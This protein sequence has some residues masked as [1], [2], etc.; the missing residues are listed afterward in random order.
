LID[1]SFLLLEKNKLLKG[2]Q[3][4][5]LGKLAVKLS[6]AGSPSLALFLLLSIG[7]GCQFEAT[8]IVCMMSA[9][10]FEL[11]NLFLDIPRERQHEEK[12][13]R[14]FRN[15]ICRVSDTSDHLNLLQTYMYFIK[16]IPNDFRLQQEKAKRGMI[17]LNVVKNAQKQALNMMRKLETIEKEALPILQDILKEKP[18][19]ENKMENIMIC[20]YGSHQAHITKPDL[21]TDLKVKCEI[22]EE[23][24]IKKIKKEYN[25]MVVYNNIKQSFNDDKPVLNIV[26]MIHG[27]N[28]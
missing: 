27:A 20:L 4:T 11:R 6:Q 25:Y 2:N 8:N 15:K 19:R 16:E 17:N 21:V 10:E 18:K 14:A 1:S 3:L 26:S 7:Y 22:S 13:I 24:T 5:P 23:T 28:L 9:C 12:S